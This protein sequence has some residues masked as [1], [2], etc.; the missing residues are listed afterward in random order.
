MSYAGRFAGWKY[1]DLAILAVA[2]ALTVVALLLAYQRDRRPAVDVG[3]LGDSPFVSGF[4]A[5]EADIDYRYRWSRGHAE[6]TF[7]GAGTARPGFVSVWAQGARPQQPAR[8]VT[9]SVSLNGVA[10]LPQVFTLTG[11]L[12]AMDLRLYRRRTAPQ[13]PSPSL[14]APTQ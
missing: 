14:P 5:D 1:R 7:T 9:M 11:E 8:P 13:A 3:D 6:V 2:L 4:Y 12:G 10:L